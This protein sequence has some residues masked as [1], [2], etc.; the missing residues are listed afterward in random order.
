MKVGLTQKTICN[1]R[2]SASAG[3]VPYG[4]MGEGGGRSRENKG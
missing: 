1:L 2:L 3:S 4:K